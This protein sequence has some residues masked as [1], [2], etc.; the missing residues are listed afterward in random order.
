VFLLDHV[1]S[2]ALEREPINVL[3]SANQGTVNGD[4]QEIWFKT[5]LKL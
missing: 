5:M 3:T 1:F 4:G 2:F